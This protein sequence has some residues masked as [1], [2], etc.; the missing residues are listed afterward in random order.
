MSNSCFI[1]ASHT[2]ASPGS[3]GTYISHGILY[4]GSFHFSFKLGKEEIRLPLGPEKKKAEPLSAAQRVE[5]QGS[6]GFLAP[7]LPPP[8]GTS[9]SPVAFVQSGEEEST[10]FINPQLQEKPPEPQHP[11]ES[12]ILPAETQ[13]HP[14][15][16]ALIPAPPPPARGGFAQDTPPDGAGEE[17]AVLADSDVHLPLLHREDPES[18]RGKPSEASPSPP[19][20]A[21][22][23]K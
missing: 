19:A 23:P 9:G 22:A 12:R 14:G 2:P 11:W 7:S 3:A 21:G 10:E 8:T 6:E 1:A 17:P 13:I 16:R 18:A 4:L 20:A 5:V 15:S